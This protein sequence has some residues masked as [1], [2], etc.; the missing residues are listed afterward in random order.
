M[1]TWEF[2]ASRQ[3]SPVRTSILAILTVAALTAAAGCNKDTTSTPAQPGPVA[4]TPAPSTPAPG[5][6]AA[7]GVS[8]VPA[9][10]PGVP[11]VKPVA[12]DLPDVVA[13]VNGE[14]IG[15]EEFQLAV[16]TL[17]GQ[18]GGAV[19]PE[20][21]DLVY[22]QVLDR[23]IGFKLLVQESRARKIAAPPW[24]VDKRLAEIKGQFPSEQAFAQVM[25]QRGMSADRLRQETADAIA[26]NS[27]LEKEIESTLTIPDADAKKFYDENKPRFRQPEGV[28]T[29][30]IL[31][32][33]PSNA[34]AAAKQKVRT[35]IEG[36]L[37]QVKKGADFAGLA[38]QHSQDGSAQ[39]GGDLGFVTRGQTV[40]PFDQAVFSMKAGQV[41]GVVE[42]QFGFHILKVG[43]ARPARDVTF[44]EAKPQITE[45]L[46]Q[47]VRDKKGQAFVDQLKAKAKIQVAI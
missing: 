27:M 16:R 19:P 45:Y 17:E 35:D 5:G 26:V 18:A 33:V 38:K 20:Q 24:D 29:S 4:G 11:A 3:E 36:I 44:D 6:P 15:R 46:K 13:T 41:S 14:K 31:L 25:Q 1:L 40:P 8:P 32:R 22:R 10:Q 47:Q 39:N 23:I 42:T 37:A 9:G 43:E 28:R 34:D 12:A 7:P 21:R 2:H 30:H